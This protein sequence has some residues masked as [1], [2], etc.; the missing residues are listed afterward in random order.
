MT[1]IWLGW[2]PDRATCGLVCPALRW[3][4]CLLQHPRALWPAILLKRQYPTER[5]E[6]GQRLTDRAE[7]SKKRGERS[8]KI[9]APQY[10]FCSLTNSWCWRQTHKML[11]P[12][13]NTRACVYLYKVLQHN[14]YA[15]T[16]TDNRR[17]PLLSFSDPLPLSL[18]DT[19]AERQRGRQ[20]H[21]ANALSHRLSAD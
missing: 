7:K 4:V 20:W 8:C 2:M 1:P 19:H 15:H 14:S 18:S 3:Q 9:E 11:L 17:L 13:E 16:H 6:K 5:K 10:Q 12:L 21:K